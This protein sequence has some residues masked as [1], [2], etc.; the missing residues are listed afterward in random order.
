MSDPKKNSAL[1]AYLEVMDEISARVE[2]EVY[3][4]ALAG[5]GVNGSP[6]NNSAN[7]LAIE[8]AALTEAE[9]KRIAGTVLVGQGPTAEEL[10][11]WDSELSNTITAKA[12][13]WEVGRLRA[14]AKHWM[15]SNA[16]VGIALD[17]EAAGLESDLLAAGMER[18]KEGPASDVVTLP[19]FDTAPPT[20]EKRWT[21]LVAPEMVP[22]PLRYAR[23]GS[24]E[25]IPH[26][27]NC[28]GGCQGTGRVPKEAMA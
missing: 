11:I 20:L 5:S 1:G 8:G 28:K 22:C 6:K 4:R 12:L 26:P 17:M 18:P 2:R 7:K 19:P 25:V 15:S 21:P 13:W 27:D 14:R 3:P 24:M 10:V 23:A 16:D 9:A